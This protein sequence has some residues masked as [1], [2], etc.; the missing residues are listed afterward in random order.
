MK[1]HNTEKYKAVLAEQLAYKRKAVL[2]LTEY[3]QCDEKD[4]FYSY[5]EGKYPEMGK[6][7]DKIYFFFH[8]LGCSMKNKEE[9]WEID[10]EFGPK[11]NALAFGKET[12]CYLLNEK[13]GAC[14]S[15][16]DYLVAENII[17]RIDKKLYALTR[18]YQKYNSWVSVQKEI[19]ASVA[20][21]YMVVED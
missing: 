17:K 21:R 19:D 15:F 16:I 5:M 2:L 10:L 18:T 20:D 7:T 9:N 8:G 4:L 14:D 11:G 13:V 3:F 6:I 1:Y 12:I